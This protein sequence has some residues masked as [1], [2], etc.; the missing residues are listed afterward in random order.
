MRFLNIWISQEGPV[1]FAGK[2][3]NIENLEIFPQPK[4]MHLWHAGSSDAVIKR[5]AH[6]C[7]GWRPRPSDPDRLRNRIQDL[8]EEAERAGRSSVRFEITNEHAVCLARV[9]EEAQ[10]ICRATLEARG[11][12]PRRPGDDATK[13]VG[14]RKQ[15][16]GS[17]ET[18][19]K[20]LRD[21]KEAGVTSVAL[22][23][24]GHTLES[25]LEQ[26]EMFAKEVIPLVA[27]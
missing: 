18:V 11:Q 9:D 2:H 26:M 12:E 5:T 4:G 1:S 19:A 6:F 8:Y 10:Q 17:P 27:K 3:L 13:T 22:A 7:D 16:V 23:F 21:D 25:I 24:I 20:V 15:C 14:S